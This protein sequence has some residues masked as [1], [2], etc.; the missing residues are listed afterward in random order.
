[1]VKKNLLSF[2]VCLL[3]FP[4]YLLALEGALTVD[5]DLYHLPSIDKFNLTIHE[6]LKEDFN[7]AM[8]FENGWGYGIDD[9]VI[10]NKQHFSVDASK[11]FPGVRYE[12]KYVRYRAW[13]E[14]AYQPK[15]RKLDDLT[16]E[17]HKGSLIKGENGKKYDLLEVN[18]CGKNHLKESICYNAEYWFEIS[19]F[20]GQGL[21][22]PAKNNIDFVD[23]DSGT[24]EINKTVRIQLLNYPLKGMI[25]QSDN[26]DDD[27]ARGGSFNFYNEKKEPIADIVVVDVTNDKTEPHVASLKSSDLKKIDEDIKKDFISQ[28]VKIQNWTPAELIENEKEKLFILNYIRLRNN[29]QLWNSTHI[30]FT[31]CKEANYPQCPS[32]GS[33]SYV[34]MGQ[35]RNNEAEVVAEFIKEII[36]NFSLNF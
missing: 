34:I 30:R 24:F 19:S 5:D 33:R 10:I 21:V 11:P 23:Q 26:I 29:D 1:M 6:I 16:F 2:L 12:Y 25:M 9:A 31:V 22:L 15:D 7:V 27:L 3:I 13:E 8:P 20:F 28:G 35:Y 17:K 14:Q 36:Y 32:S 4:S 18:I